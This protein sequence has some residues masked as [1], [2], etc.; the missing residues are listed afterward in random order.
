MVGSR[1]AIGRIEVDP[2]MRALRVD[3]M[4]LAA[5]EATLRL[6]MDA[7]HAVERIPLWTM[8]AAPLPMLTARAE[9]LA[10]IFRVGARA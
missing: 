7:E 8:I 3:K 10:A 1:E 6:A 5:L 2:L 9:A 4:T